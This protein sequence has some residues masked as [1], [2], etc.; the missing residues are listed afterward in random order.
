MAIYLVMSNDV[1]PLYYDY[2]GFAKELCEVPGKA[3]AR[4]NWPRRSLTY[5][6]R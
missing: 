5:S 2:Y 3:M 1:N 4:T 6:K